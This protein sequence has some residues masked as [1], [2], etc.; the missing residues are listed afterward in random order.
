[1][2]SGSGHVQVFLDVD[3]FCACSIDHLEGHDGGRGRGE[4]SCLGRNS[5]DLAAQG[6]CGTAA[7]HDE[8]EPNVGQQVGDDDGA[9]DLESSLHEIFP[10]SVRYG[11][12]ESVIY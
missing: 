1:M 9:D 5:D 8:L 6:S 7:G 10:C 12:I 11:C 3:L 4:L 2:G